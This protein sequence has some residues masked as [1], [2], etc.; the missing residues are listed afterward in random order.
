MSHKDNSPSSPENFSKLTGRLPSPLK[1]AQQARNNS[2]VSP[3]KVTFE[4]LT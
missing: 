4:T 1:I 3:K 2:V